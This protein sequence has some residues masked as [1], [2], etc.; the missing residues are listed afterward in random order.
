MIKRRALAKRHHQPRRPTYIAAQIIMP[1]QVSSVPCVVREISP[2]G[3]RLDIDAAWIMPRS[4]L[5]RMEGNTCMHSCTV[6]WRNG[7]DVGV[8]FAPG[9]D[10]TGW[11]SSQGIP[12]QM[13]NPARI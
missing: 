9:R 12:N 4:F 3:A 7:L 11:Q 6:V 5:L 8:K 2:A 10:K 1:G 13:P